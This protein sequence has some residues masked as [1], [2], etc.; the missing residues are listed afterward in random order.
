MGRHVRQGRTPGPLPGEGERPGG[1]GGGTLAGPAEQVGQ[2]PEADHQQERHDRH[3]EPAADRGGEERGDVGGG[4]RPADDAAEERE[5]PQARVDQ[6]FRRGLVVG[7][8]VEPVEQPAADDGPRYRAEGDVE[9]VVAAQPLLAGLVGPAGEPRGE[10]EAQEERGGE[11]EGQRGG[12]HP[13]QC[14]RRAAAPQAAAR[15]RQPFRKSPRR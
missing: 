4:D 8:E 14:R 2:L 6:A 10:G 3:V 1:V 5:A 12:G 11:D 15:E 9:E 13:R 7:Q